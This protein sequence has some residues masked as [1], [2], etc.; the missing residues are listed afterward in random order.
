[1]P[2]I[3]VC[4]APETSAQLDGKW[5]SESLDHFTC[6]AQSIESPCCPQSFQHQITRLQLDEAAIGK[7]TRHTEQR[8]SYVFLASLD[9]QHFRDTVE[10][11]IRPWVVTR[12]V[13]TRDLTSLKIVLLGRL[14][15]QSYVN[16]YMGRILIWESVIIHF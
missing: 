6:N 1:M 13:N 10:C 11:L 3:G 2:V 14:Q 7:K 15:R 9:N 4:V 5:D 8:H 16:E 12:C